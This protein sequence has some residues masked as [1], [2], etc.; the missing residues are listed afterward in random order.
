MHM[1]F[2]YLQQKCNNQ[3]GAASVVSWC[4]FILYKL[5]SLLSKKNVNKKANL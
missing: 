4:L 2:I 1:D 5:I 3:A